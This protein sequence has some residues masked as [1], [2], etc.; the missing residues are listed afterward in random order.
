M[1]GSALAPTH[2]FWPVGEAAQANYETLR[3][4]V[5]TGEGLLD[6]LATANLGA[7]RFARRGLAGLIAWPSAEPVFAA[8]LRGATRPPWT[9]ADADPRLEALAAGFAL[10]LG[11]PPAVTSSTTGLTTG[12]SRES[13]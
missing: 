9:P 8:T 11:Q 6:E 1:S 12:P 3:A 7:A 2:R 10:L 13:G 5:L 4:R